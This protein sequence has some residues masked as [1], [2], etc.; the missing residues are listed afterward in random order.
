MK[1]VSL[2]LFVFARDV[3]KMLI[4]CRAE[5]EEKEGLLVPQS[6][7]GVYQ[8]SANGKMKKMESIEEALERETREELGNIFAERFFGDSN[9]KLIRLPKRKFFVKGKESIA[10][11]FLGEISAEQAK[12]IELHKGADKLILIGRE[13]I[14]R[15]KK[16]DD[17]SRKKG[18]IIFFPDQYPVIIDL[19]DNIEK[20]IKK[21]EKQRQSRSC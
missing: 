19:L 16:K 3:Y 9:C 6:F 11:N 14:F 13:D 12:L 10:Y 15:I 17:V 1:T 4:Q 21:L 2:Y 7:P 8:P 5:K 20:F 18:D